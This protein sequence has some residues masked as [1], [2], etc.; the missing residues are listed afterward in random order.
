MERVLREKMAR[1][2]VF[3]RSTISTGTKDFEKAESDKREY[4]QKGAK[5]SVIPR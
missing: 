2:R 5:L 1:N 4:N 3:W